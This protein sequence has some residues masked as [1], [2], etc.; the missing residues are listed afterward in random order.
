MGKVGEGTRKG[1]W[2]DYET[3]RDCV[4]GKSAPIGDGVQIGDR[5]KVEAFAFLPGYPRRP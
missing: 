3:G 2:G 4:M 1:L 5:C